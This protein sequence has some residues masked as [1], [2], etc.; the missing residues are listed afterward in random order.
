[1]ETEH[2]ALRSAEDL[3]PVDVP[4]LG[5]KHRPP[6]GALTDRR[7]TAAES[8]MQSALPEES[9]FPGGEETVELPQDVAEQ[10]AAAARCPD[11]VENL[12]HCFSA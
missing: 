6:D 9:R 10:G 3:D 2:A 11:D 4:L 7:L 12:H 8:V 1:V 5:S